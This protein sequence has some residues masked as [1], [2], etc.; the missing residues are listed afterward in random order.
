MRRI[1]H[2][3]PP[4]GVTLEIR[5]HADALLSKA[6][7]YDAFPTPVMDLVAAAGLGV[8]NTLFTDE[9]IL[10]RMDT[11]PME[12]VKRARGELLGLVDLRGGT[13]Y[14]RPE[15][16][17]ADLPPLVLHET[18]H[19]YLAWQR[20]I[21]LFVQEDGAGLDPGIKDQFE[22]EANLFAWELVF[23]VDRFR[24]DAEGD[25]FSLRT[26]VKLARRYGTTPYAAVRRFAETNRRPCAILISSR[27][28]RG[29][30]QRWTDRR[31]VQSPSF[32]RRFGEIAGPVI[33]RGMAGG[34][35]GGADYGARYPVRLRDLAGRDVQCEVHSH[36]TEDHH[37]KL[38]YPEDVLS[39]VLV[40]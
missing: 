39:A 30:G 13:I 37:F 31:P 40:R 34:T 27:T 20:E 17:L 1:D 26:P 19:A 4:S 23:Q 22:Y 18:A 8:E 33:D 10:R 5:R 16:S 15:V 32:T 12:R 6:G 29:G 11:A 25:E 3:E 35:S 21:Y 24:E 2:R 14:V 7:A 9:R 28:T 36:L 38:I